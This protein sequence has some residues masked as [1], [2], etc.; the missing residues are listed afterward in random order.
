MGVLGP[1][2]VLTN[3]ANTL[4]CARSSGSR[5]FAS[6]LGGL[7]G[8]ALFALVTVKVEA[9]I[10][11]KLHSWSPEAPPPDWAEELGRW[12]RG[13]RARTA[14][15]LAGLSSLLLGVIRSR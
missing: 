14:A 8:V 13:H 12:E 10:N 5:G 9:P 15:I 7:L 2:V 4:S 11:E 6:A 3:V 1:L